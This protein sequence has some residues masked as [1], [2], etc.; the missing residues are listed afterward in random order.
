MRTGGLQMKIAKGQKVLFIG[1]S[2]TDCERARPVGEG[3]NGAVGR[4]YVSLIDALL[5][6][7]YPELG[8]RIVN[9]GVS[10]NNVRDLR[11]RWETDVIQQKPDWLVIMIGINDVWRQF[12]SPF[13][14]TSHVYIEEYE[15]ML[16]ELVKEAK[17]LTKQLVLMTPFFIEANRQ[18][19]M[20]QQMD[21][22]GG[23]VKRIAE[24]NEALFVDTQAAFDSVLNTLYS[25]TL[26]LDRVHP[27]QTG[28]MVLARAFLNQ[29]GFDWIRG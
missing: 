5:Q 12:H 6:S 23:V 25:G 24:E 8:I 2:I 9:M 16:R 7:G 21:Q 11:A 1:D 13:I 15:N 22:Y 4:G 26:A 14:P 3:L 17:P 29:I 27:T 28:H 20:R 10:A 18:D 19:L